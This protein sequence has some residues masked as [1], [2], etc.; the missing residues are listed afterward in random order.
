MGATIKT[1]KRMKRKLK[2]KASIKL[3]HCASCRRVLS[4]SDQILCCNRRW[5]FGDGASEPACYMNSL[6]SGQYEVRN[7]FEQHLS[8]GLFD[9]ADV[10]CACGKQVGYKFIC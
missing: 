2:T 8:Q 5:G 4:T 1:G 6:C 3:L 7:V 9:M 10:Y